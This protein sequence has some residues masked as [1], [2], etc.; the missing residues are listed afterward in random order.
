[1]RL[2]LY[3][4]ITLL[5]ISQTH[6]AIDLVQ[7]EDNSY[8]SA[9]NV[10]FEYYPTATNIS[11][12]TLTI[13]EQQF[14][15]FSIQSNEFN[16][17]TVVNIAK[18]AHAWTI[19]CTAATQEQ[20]TTRTLYIDR[21]PP[22]LQITQLTQVPEITLKATDA[23]SKTLECSINANANLIAQKT[24]QNNTPTT[25][26]LD[27]AD[28][29]YSLLITC[30][31]KA[32]N[33]KVATKNVS[34][35]APKAQLYLNISTNKPSYGLG[36][37]IG[38]TILSLEN[39][40]VTIEVCPDKLGFVECLTPITTTNFPQALVLPYANITGK[41]LIDGIARF[42]DQTVFAQARYEVINTM[43]VTITADETPKFDNTFTLQ[44][45]ATGAIGKVNYT[46]KLTNGSTMTGE[47]I[48]LRYLTIG[49]HIEKV[50]ATDSKGNIANATYNANI[51]PV[52]EQTVI[53]KNAQTQAL[54]A[55]ASVQF[56]LENGA[57]TTEITNN[58]GQAIFYLDD[59]TYKLFISRVGFEYYLSEK[60]VS[61]KETTTIEL[62]PKSLAIPKVTILSPNNN[63]DIAK[64][65]D[66]RFMLE[67]DKKATCTLS[68]AL[69]GNEWF[70]EAGT[71]Q[72]APGDE[73]S[74]PLSVEPGTYQLFV[75]C[76]DDTQKSA[77]SQIITLTATQEV[78]L[79]QPATS[80][81][82][83][84]E[85]DSLA[86]IDAAYGAYDSFS[87]GQRELANLLDWESIIKEKKRT[88][89]RGQRDID[90]VRYRRDLSDAEKEQEE[91][92]IAQEIQ[93]AR[94]TTPVDLVLVDQESSVDYLQES[95]IK[96]LAAQLIEQKDYAFT[97]EQLENYITQVQQ[98]FS[99]KTTFYK[100]T[101]YLSDSTQVPLSI[102]THELTYKA[103]NEDGLSLYV[104]MPPE[105]ATTPTQIVTNHEIEILKNSP[106]SIEFPA[107]ELIA[108]YVE[109]DVSLDTLK[110]TKLLLLK[111]PTAQDINLIT[112]NASLIALDVKTSIIIS[113]LLILF[114][115][116]ASRF[117]LIHHIKYLLYAKSRKKPLHS[118]R[119]IINDGIAQ[120]Q[121]NN[122]DRAMMRYKE[123]KLSYEQLKTYAQNEIY[124][125]MISFKE[126][127][128]SSYF[129]MLTERIQ[130]SI[131]QGN[132]D[133]AIDDFERLEGTFN[134][135]TPD[136]QDHLITIVTTIAKKLGVDVE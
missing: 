19:S 103:D 40:N 56:Q 123:A 93:T 105:V 14:Q 70:S 4:F 90:T 29:N 127:L 43:G 33:A 34:L 87:P 78:T 85:E 46:W 135:L 25:I 59:E 75:E 21:T 91:Q 89:E 12:C 51:E 84:L 47:K 83:Y 131:Q 31:D 108:Y 125:E 16:K 79:A 102:V 1:M 73:S 68:Y 54:L 129:T 116:L 133:S 72:V 132:L 111:E 77:Q 99:P 22:I 57:T 32:G 63:D 86:V 39:A 35:K 110:K 88:I 67:Y 28:G 92:R 71:I 126:A 52:F 61:K 64:Q 134:K 15:D 24:V 76:I 44:A 18:G 98:L 11:Q 53:V 82:I 62:T 113:A 97:Q 23:Q 136:D 81:D 101:I 6:A 36:Q 55:N 124:E 45:K 96:E 7:P 95:D 120:L 115:F 30:L 100:A 17:F 94:A 69:Q 38:L 112:A 49:D 130:D 37:Q 5:L 20:S 13:D 3:I 2:P 26:P 50:I 65:T 118:L 74:I 104:T 9:N 114:L 121:A 48:T 10:T 41:Y 58:N 119:T 109:N 122:L 117:H 60:A 66:I 80:I 8:V 27:L 106:P 42:D 128:D 107:Q